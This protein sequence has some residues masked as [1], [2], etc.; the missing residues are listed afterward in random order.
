[1]FI[2]AY[3]KSLL[4]MRTDLERIGWRM[5][6]RNLQNWHPTQLAFILA[7]SAERTKVHKKKLNFAGTA[8][9]T[10]SRLR[11][12]RVI[13]KCAVSNFLSNELISLKSDPLTHFSNKIQIQCLIDIRWLNEIWLIEMFGWNWTSQCEV[14]KRSVNCVDRSV[15]QWRM[16]SQ[17]QQTES[18][19]S[20]S[21]KFR[22]K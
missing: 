12:G 14:G 11:M 8:W 19:L 20:N 6:V 1:M 10:W 4:K 3:L 15:G 13:W 9:L 5:V 16:G 21:D 2:I 17:S 7:Q 22:P 18:C